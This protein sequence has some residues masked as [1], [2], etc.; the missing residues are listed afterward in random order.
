MGHSPFGFWRHFWKTSLHFLSLNPPS[1]VHIAI[2]VHLGSDEPY[3]AT[4]LGNR[5]TPPGGSPPSE[6]QAIAQTAVI[7]SGCALSWALVPL[8]QVLWVL[9]KENCPQISLDSLNYPP[10][11]PPSPPCWDS[12]ASSVRHRLPSLLFRVCSPQSAVPQSSH[13]QPPVLR[14]RSGGVG[15]GLF[16]RGSGITTHTTGLPPSYFLS[17]SAENSGTKHTVC[18]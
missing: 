17:L 18:V 1:M 10:S 6:S 9:G 2:H 11:P 8:D 15:S 14:S 4:V 3:S 13:T 16:S 7:W 5:G 12:G